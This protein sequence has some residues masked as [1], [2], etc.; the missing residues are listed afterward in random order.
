[1]SFILSPCIVWRNHYS[2]DW[3]RETTFSQKLNW[4]LFGGEGVKKFWISQVCIM[5]IKTKHM[6]AKEL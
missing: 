1:M 4:S 6:K 2:W 3:D 5:Q